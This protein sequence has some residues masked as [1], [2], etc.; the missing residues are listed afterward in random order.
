MT[1]APETPSSGSFA[2]VAKDTGISLSRDISP[3]P[4]VGEVAL[5][6]LSLNQEAQVPTSSSDTGSQS[7]VVFPAHDSMRV[8]TTITYGTFG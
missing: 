1:K 7:E 3:P 4:G 8:P 6:P 5:L 2:Q